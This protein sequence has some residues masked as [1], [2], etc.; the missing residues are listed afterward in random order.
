MSF[1]TIC[2][3][4][5]PLVQAL[6]LPVCPTRSSHASECLCR[7]CERWRGCSLGMSLSWQPDPSDVTS[8]VC[9]FSHWTD[10]QVKGTSLPRALHCWDRSLHESNKNGKA[11]LKG[12]PIHLIDSCP[13]PH[14]N[15]SCPTIRDQFTGQEMNVIQFLM[16][17][18]FDVQKMAQQQGLEPSKLLGMLSSG[19]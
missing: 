13:W 12:C 15:P 9:L 3:S 18:G 7:S 19:N 1:Q 17:M 4:F 14:C 10:I 6:L 2:V 8:V 16:H 11:P 5:C